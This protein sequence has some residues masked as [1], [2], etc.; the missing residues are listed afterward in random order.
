MKYEII[1]KEETVVVKID[2]DGIVESFDMTEP[3]AEG[4]LL[5]EKSKKDVLGEINLVK[6]L[7]NLDNCVDLLQITFN[8][9]DGFSVQSKVQTLSN[10]FIDAM[11]KSNA[12]ALEFKLA[13][14]NAM[15]A[16]INAYAYLF[17][18]ETEIAME[19]L[20][21]TKSDAA[22]MVKKAEELVCIYDKLTT[23]TNG[24]LTEVMKER[25]EDEKKREETNSMI[26][27]LEGSIRAMEELKQN[28]RKD[29]EQF[30]ADYK[31]L[32]EREMK[33][34][35]RAY[36]L[37]LASMIIGAV[38]GIFGVA[39]D[40]IM[41][42]GRDERDQAET[43]SETGEVSVEVQTKREY[44]NNINE[45]EAKKLAIHKAETRIEKLDELLDGQYYI[46]GANHESADPTDVDTQKTDEELRQEKQAK[47][48]EIGKL[49]NE[50]STLKG[51]E[52]ALSNT[53]SGLGLVMDK[54]AED[55]RNNAREIRKVADSLAE[56]MD[57]ISKKRDDLKQQERE[58]LVKLA[59]NT[60][61]MQNMVMDAN[62]LES[63]IQCLVIAV[64]CL[65]RVLAYLQ[66]IKLF[67]MNIETFCD[68]LA[69]N[70]NITKLITIQSGKE[71]EQRAAYFKT[72]LFVQ[73]YIGVI[74]K[75]KAL[76]VIFAEYLV[77][78]ST[79]STRMSQT[80][81]QSLSADRKEQWKLATQLAGNLKEKLNV[82]LA[83]Q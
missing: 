41:N 81:E 65:R 45:Q 35:E 47:V 51:Q 52:Q 32:Q 58:N 64:G 55:T 18:G 9:V 69:A 56:R 22:R 77:A 75:W 19:L 17:S 13:T 78:L 57:V 67:W 54:V 46:G 3:P 34:E 62:S 50:L 66:E 83:E 63:A 15:E 28:L 8:A 4:S 7:T 76:H 59:E 2:E 10:N 5:V 40:G 1:P 20:K 38:N 37:Q 26:K 71:P 6:M 14:E 49:N 53:L 27:E 61:K 39:T 68:N 36:D 42:G 80:L 72:R 44:T 82:E 11:N 24:A 70:D 43:A 73:G 48:D 31:K 30:E 23:D 16:Y 79:V 33:Q 60:A 25:A 29:I 74:A 12:T 21:D